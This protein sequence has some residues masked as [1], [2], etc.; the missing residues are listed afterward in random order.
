MSLPAHTPAVLAH[1][2]G[3]KVEFHGYMFPVGERIATWR[4]ESGVKLYTLQTIET[5]RESV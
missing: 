5:S 4:T 1:D 2:S 3:K